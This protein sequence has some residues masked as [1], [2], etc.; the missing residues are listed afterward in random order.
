MK[1]IAKIL[2][3]F[4]CLVIYIACDNSKI[5]MDLKLASHAL[6][7]VDPMPT[8]PGTNSDVLSDDLGIA[9][10]ALSDAISDENIS[11]IQLGLSS[12]FTRIRIRSANALGKLR[13]PAA[14]KS[15]IKALQENQGIIGGG[16]ETQIEQ[17]ELTREILFALERITKIKF[18]ASDR[19]AASDLKGYAPL[20]SNE[21]KEIITKIDHWCESDKCS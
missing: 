8:P 20:S 12:R 10:P 3:V 7:V 2:T 13:D 17:A 4:F 16:T 18:E 6:T 21:L 15:L 14:I 9:D 5:A 1:Q 19:L 11:I